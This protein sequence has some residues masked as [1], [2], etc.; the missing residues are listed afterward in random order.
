MVSK[1]SQHGAAG[2]VLANGSM[3]TNTSSEG[4]I[5]QQILESDLVDCMI[6]LPGQLFYTTQIPVCLWFITRS[7]KSDEAKGH[8]DRQ[9]ETLFIDAR[10]IG[11]MIDRTHKELSSDDIAGIAD[12]YHQWRS[13]NTLTPPGR[14]AGGEGVSM[15][16]RQAIANPPHS[17]T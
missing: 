6:A 5:R 12:T 8:R 13:E 4:K 7:K 15:K 16:T 11:S 2:F 1:L 9:G 14:G 17:K 10:N 3:S